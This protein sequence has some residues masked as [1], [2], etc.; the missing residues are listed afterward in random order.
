[1]LLLAYKPV[2]TWVDEQGPTAAEA[3][4]LVIIPKQD[5]Y[6]ASWFPKN[7]TRESCGQTP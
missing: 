7:N 4:K 6:R 3:G 2:L 1:M 5:T